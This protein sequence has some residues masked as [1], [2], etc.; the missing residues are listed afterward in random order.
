[1]HINIKASISICFVLVALLSEAQNKKAI[2]FNTKAQ[3]ILYYLKHPSKTNILAVAHRGAW[4]QAPENSLLAIQRCIDMGVDI[5]EIDV[6]LT[7]DSQLVVIH[8]LTL[9]RTTTGKGKVADYTLAELKKFRLKNAVGI[10]WSTKQQIPTLEEAML[11]A[12]GKIMINL[13]KTEAAT[14]RQAYEVLKKTGTVDHGIFKGNDSVQVMRQKFGALMDSIIYMPKVW[15]SL[16]NISSYVANFNQDVKPAV[17]EMLFDNTA[18]PVFSIIKEMNVNKISV[19][20]IA[21]WD[22]LCA[23]YSDEMAITQGADKAYGWLISNGANAIM[24]DHPEAL[25]NYLRKRKLHK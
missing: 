18:S 22:D 5:A 16:P 14:L 17:Y 19:L 12:K 10:P 6:R 2:R 15:Y 25:L 7:K 9:D 13:D 8:D 3:E 4:S 1:M 11:L 20:A 24:T 21:L 23:G